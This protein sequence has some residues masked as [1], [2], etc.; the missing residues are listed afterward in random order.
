MIHLITITKL[1]EE[2]YIIEEDIDGGPV[3]EQR[4][5][6]IAKDYASLPAHHFRSHV[7]ANVARVVYSHKVLNIEQVEI[8]SIE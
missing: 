8:K 6:E 7:S 2:K 4:A 3:D 5:I 1:V